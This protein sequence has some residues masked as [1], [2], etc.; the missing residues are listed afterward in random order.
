[1]N[2]QPICREILRG[3]WMS[4][5]CRSIDDADHLEL[6]KIADEIKD[7]RV[8]PLKK[9]ASGGLAHMLGE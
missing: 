8:V 2:P 5:Y 3:V 9:K 4:R 1:M 6:K 7:I